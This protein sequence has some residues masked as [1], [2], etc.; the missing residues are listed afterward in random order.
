LAEQQAEQGKK[1]AALEK[2]LAVED[3]MKNVGHWGFLLQI[4]ESDNSYMAKEKDFMQKAG[5]MKMRFQNATSVYLDIS[6]DDDLSRLGAQMQ[7][8]GCNCNMAE[9]RKNAEYLVSVKNKLS[10]CSGESGT[11]FCYANAT[12]TVNNLKFQK[13][14]NVNIPEAKGGWVKGDREKASEEAFKKLTSSL[15]EKI[16]Q[17]INQ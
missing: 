9:N 15:A 13:P 14:I 2:I 12:V 6:G 4:V 7:E 11:V 3:S 5:N 8:K 17:T 10:R 16:N 1:K